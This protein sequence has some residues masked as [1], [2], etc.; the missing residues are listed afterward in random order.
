MSESRMQM[1]DWMKVVSAMEDDRWAV[2]LVPMLRLHWFIRLRWIFLGGAIAALAFERFVLPGVR[3]PAALA[4]LLIVL[5]SVNVGWLVISH[6]LFRRVSES[7]S[8]LRAELDRM[9]VFANA[10]V[11]VDLLL[12]TSILRYTGGAE[13]PLSMFYLF[14]MAIVSLLLKRTHAILQGC[15]ALLLY[16]TLVI[17]EWRGWLTPH[18][19]FLPTC[20]LGVYSEPAYV[21]AVV[22]V[23]GCGIFGMLYFTLRIASQ[24]QAQERQ[25]QRANAALQQSQQAIQDLQRR[26]SRFMQIA[27]HQLKS[28]LAAI[29]TM[30]ELI[31]SNIVPPE[32]VPGTC[33]KIIRRCQDGIAQVSE[34]LTLARVQEADP[35]RHRRSHADVREVVLELQGRLKPL[36]EGKSI[37]F[38][39]SI[40]PDEELIVAVD[41]RDL[42]DCIG[43]LMDN[44]IKYT[45]AQGRVEVTVMPERSD[46]KLKAVL[47]SVS[48]TGMGIDP[49]LVRS[50]DGE[51]GHEPVFD[52]FRRG[53]NAIAAGIPGTGL[54]L[55]IVREVVEQAG[56]RIVVSSYPGQ[57]SSFTLTLPSPGAMVGRPQ[58]RDTRASTVVLESPGVDM[59]HKQELTKA[60]Q[61][62]RGR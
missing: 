12:L 47:V 40:P 29:Q 43:N 1:A 4:G 15:W 26:R 58:V 46:G 24:L 50:P 20:P 11:A 21:L 9:V 35:A 22:V 37:T 31:R 56:G 51:P 2:A 52:A 61:E 23:V 28:P 30:T 44:A 41:P 7:P 19:D 6:L 42:H 36:A 13:N 25:L 5:A 14:H 53:A 8:T 57:G 62:A 16:A 10:Q 32:A 27:A 55:S 17:G 59:A 18:Y 48:D 39:C 49:Q 3:R 60:T 34:L 33:E 45:P 38:T 54:G